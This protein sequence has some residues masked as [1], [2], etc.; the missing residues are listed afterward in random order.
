MHTWTLLLLG[1]VTLAAALPEKLHQLAGE[2]DE[3]EEGVDY[4]DEPKR[5]YSFSYAASRYYNGAPDREHQEQRGE[6]GIT[7]G[8]FRYVDPRHKVQEVVYFA[9]EGGFHVEASNLPQETLAVQN[10]R[11]KHQELFE[12]IREEHARIGAERALLE[13]ENTDDEKYQ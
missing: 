4:E 11:L 1:L 7:R 3:D 2:A 10:A 6:D 5:P 8:V 12:K 13:S 9:D